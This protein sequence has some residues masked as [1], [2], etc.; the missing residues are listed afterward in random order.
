M[1]PVIRPASTVK[2]QQVHA[3]SYHPQIR[4]VLKGGPDKMW[5]VKEIM[6]LIGFRERAVQEMLANGTLD[7]T[8][9]PTTK[10][11]QRPR[12]RA[13]AGSLLL[14]L[15][16][17]SSEMSEADTLGSLG[18]ILDQLP[19][20]VLTQLISYLQKKV[21]ARA[22]QPVLVVTAEAPMQATAQMD[23]FQ[24]V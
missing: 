24:S 3:L 9:Y 12:R 22:S 19:S 23:L 1:H 8:S 13:R 16:K 7:N 5:D 15:V 6:D 14:Y 4:K 20:S 10:T 17:N 2:P 11:V 18:V 21:A